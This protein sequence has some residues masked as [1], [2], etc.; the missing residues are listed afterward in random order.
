[1]F[2]T[3]LDIVDSGVVSDIVSPDNI[4]DGYGQSAGNNNLE[5]GILIGFSLAV[6]LWVIIKL[7]I[8]LFKKTFYDKNEEE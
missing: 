8:Y 4:P 2:G 3:L 5:I 7:S 6:V 1:M